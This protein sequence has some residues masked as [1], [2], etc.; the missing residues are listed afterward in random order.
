RG[1]QIDRG[2]TVGVDVA[3]RLSAR[4]AEDVGPLAAGEGRPHGVDVVVA[5][6]EVAVVDLDVGVL[7]VERRDVL[8]RDGRC[9]GPAPPADRALGLGSFRSRAGVTGAGPETPGQTERE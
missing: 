2:V 4:D 3:R 9:R 5:H 7:L 6:A 8:L 1:L